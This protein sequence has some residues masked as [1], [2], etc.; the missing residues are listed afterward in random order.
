MKI[1]QGNTVLQAPLLHSTVNQGSLTV[2]EVHRAGRDQRIVRLKEVGF[3]R[4]LF[5]EVIAEERPKESN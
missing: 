4:D 1:K 2:C 5:I 3:R